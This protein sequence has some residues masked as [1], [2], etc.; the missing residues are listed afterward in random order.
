M[1]KQEIM[2]VVQEQHDQPIKFYDSDKRY[3][4]WYYV[5]G[6]RKQ[7]AKNNIDDLYLELY[8]HITGKLKEDVLA[9]PTI[10]MMY[11]RWLEWKSL[12]TQSPS[13]ITRIE[14][15]WNN[16]YKGTE[17]VSM[18]IE[19][20]TPSILDIWA[21]KLIIDNNMTSKQYYNMSMIA[22]QIL[23]YSVHV[24]HVIPFN[25]FDMVKIDGSRLFRKPKKK[26]SE[27]QVFTNDEKS[28]MKSLA[29]EDF[30]NNRYPVNLLTPL[31]MIFQFETGMRISEVVALKY[32]DINE[33]EITVHRMYRESSRDV[34]DD[35]KGTFGERFV[36]LTDDALEVIEAVN[37]KKKELKIK[38]EYIFSLNDEPLSY[39]ALRKLY[40]KY[41]ARLSITSR[42]SHKAR[43]TYISTLIDGGVN[44]NTIREMVGHNDERTTLN[45]YCY[46]RNSADERKK[47]IKRALKS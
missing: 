39:Y 14:S 31:A 13:Y 33:D 17:L 44:I 25:P 22:R 24:A 16:H 9:V 21:H 45:C 38:N 36:T 28:Q 27:T 4:T 23:D 41:C 2:Q 15:V 1:K 18:P 8:C 20:I 35:T 42:S 32:E 43:K 6:K 46:D 26:S 11:P 37:R 30:E 3:H 29:W 40:P 7:L 19:E 12:H 47:Q 34:V 5:D 10:E